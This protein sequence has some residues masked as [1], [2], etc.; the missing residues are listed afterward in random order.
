MEHIQSR[1]PELVHACPDTSQ[2]SARESID[3]TKR[4]V[5]KVMLLMRLSVTGQKN[6]A[7]IS[8]L[9]MQALG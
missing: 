1:L 8:R 9:V 6:T 7:P 3:S 2:N 4:I 5:S